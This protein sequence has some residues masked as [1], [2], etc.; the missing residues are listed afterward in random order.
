V[1]LVRLTNDKRLARPSALYGEPPPGQGPGGR[2][3][4]APG[5]LV[6]SERVLQPNDVYDIDLRSIFYEF[7]PF[8]LHHHFVRFFENERYTDLGANLRWF[9]KRNRDLL[10]SEEAPITSNDDRALFKR[11]YR[12]YLARQA[13]TVDQWLASLPAP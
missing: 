1:N 10:A 3:G 7:P 5:A 8:P 9:S 13:D 11:L 12:S 6:E 4:A 2:V